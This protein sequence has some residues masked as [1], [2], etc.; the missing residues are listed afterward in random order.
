MRLVQIRLRDSRPFWFVGDIHLTPDNPA[1]DFIDIDSLDQKT[2]VVIDRSARRLLVDLYN[3]DG[4]RVDNFGGLTH[5]SSIESKEILPAPA[6]MD[7]IES[8]TIDDEPEEAPLEVIDCSEEAKV[9]VDKNGNVVK[10]IVRNL[11]KNHKNLCLLNDMLSAESVG[12]NR[13]G[14]CKALETAIGEYDD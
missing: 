13:A 1:S 3:T 4:I 5:S 8:V 11:P 10:K 7:S 9:L 2:L 6:E 14:V 12:K